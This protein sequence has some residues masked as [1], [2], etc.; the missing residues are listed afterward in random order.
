MDPELLN[1]KGH[2]G[3]FIITLEEILSGLS[4]SSLKCPLYA[5]VELKMH[6][7]KT[8]TISNFLIIGSWHYELSP[9]QAA[10]S[11]G[12]EDGHV[13]LV[14]IL[15]W[16]LGTEIEPWWLEQPPFPLSR[17]TLLLQGSISRGF[18]QA[19]FLLCE[20]W[21][22]QQTPYPWNLRGVLLVLVL[23]PFLKTQVKFTQC[24]INHFKPYSSV[25]FSIFTY[26]TTTTSI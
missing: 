11:S 19:Q 14:V 12:E 1:I 9:S 21:A 13:M 8:P 23:P 7:H 25:A 5:E 22:M 18:L 16:P 26:R 24:E 2:F 4:S 3:V 10:T 17:W 15:H 6:C 20:L